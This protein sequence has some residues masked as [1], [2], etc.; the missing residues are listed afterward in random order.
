MIFKGHCKLNTRKYFT[1]R[2]INVWNKLPHEAVDCISINMFKSFLTN[3]SLRHLMGDCIESVT[4]FPVSHLPSQ[5]TH[6]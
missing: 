3:D 1:R 2:V 5:V 6:T 4:P